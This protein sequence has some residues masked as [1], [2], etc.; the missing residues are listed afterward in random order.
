MCNQKIS[1][2]LLAWTAAVLLAIGMGVSADADTVQPGV[3]YYVDSTA[4]SDTASGTSESQAWKS[5]DRVNSTVFQP[6]DRILMKSGSVF[7]GHLY[8]SGSG[9][10]EAPIVIDSYGEG[11]K[12][13]TAAA[14][15]TVETIAIISV[16]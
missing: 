7:V 14:M 1:K 4:G 10:A 8:P 11:A 9:S 12:P 13:M 15:I 6:G 3:T 5:L 2:W 16:V